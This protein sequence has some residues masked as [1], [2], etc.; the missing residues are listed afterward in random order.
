MSSQNEAIFRGKGLSLRIPERVFSA[1]NDCSQVEMLTPEGF[2]VIIGSRTKA[3][4]EYW[5]DNITTPYSG[6]QATR[7][8]FK[9]QDTNHQK[10]V[11]MAFQR[12]GGTCIYLGIW[13]THPELAPMPSTVDKKDWVACIRR[14]PGR[15]L[16]FVIVGLNEIRVFVR[17]RWCLGFTQLKKDG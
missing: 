4:N 7:S 11:D 2:G 9:L 13:H 15:Q 5:V 16:F 10:L 8:S 6:D 17:S 14:N 3:R 1:W 12:S